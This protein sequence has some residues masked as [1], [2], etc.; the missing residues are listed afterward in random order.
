MS[1]INRLLVLNQ[2]VSW[3]LSHLILSCFFFIRLNRSDKILNTI[4]SYFFVKK[5][6]ILNNLFTFRSSILC[7]N[8][9]EQIFGAVLSHNWSFAGL[10]AHFRALFFLHSDLLV[11]NLNAL[12]FLV[13]TLKLKVIKFDYL[14]WWLLDRLYLSRTLLWL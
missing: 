5:T 4:L 7:F 13:E 1:I 3:I 8:L 9:L 14:F 6:L 12:I 10:D 11:D 2:D